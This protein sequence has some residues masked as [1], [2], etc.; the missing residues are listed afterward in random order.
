MSS[1]Q[2]CYVRQNALLTQC[3]S[4]RPIIII[5][6]AVQSVRAALVASCSE[7]FLVKSD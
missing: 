2:C 6:T 5:Q 4:V 7:I 1:S 3:V